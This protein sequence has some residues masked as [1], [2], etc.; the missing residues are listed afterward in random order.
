[1]AAQLGAEVTVVDEDGLGGACVLTDCVPS[2]TLI[3]SSST[4]TSLGRVG[5]ARPGARGRRQPGGRGGRAR[6]NARIKALAA[7]Q[8]N[9]IA[10]HV[11]RRGRADHRG[12][13]RLTGPHTIE[14]GGTTV[15]ADVRADRD[16]ARSPRVAARRGARRRAHPDLP[17]ALRPGRAAG[18]A[19]RGRL[20]RDRRRVRRAPTRRSARRSRWSRRAS[21]CCRTRTRTPPIVI[22]GVFRR[23]GMN[24]L[25][26]S[27]A[28]AVHRK[29]DG[30]VVTL[31]DGRH[32]DRLA[33][34][35]DGRHGAVH[36]RD[37]PAR[38]GRQPGQRA[39]SSRWT[40]CR[41]RRRPACTRPATA[42]AC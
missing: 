36:G 8:S 4:M 18:R 38:R 34:P 24:V 31:A 1:M 2:K 35:A 30:V 26:R 11:G 37:R 16:R 41:G 6:L 40:G 33:L 23:R 9:D 13:G 28:E 21:G 25:G 22:E 12:Q 27:R 19:D 39:A 20:R 15:H 3:E 29:G 42:R 10:E 14:A 7:A 17:P 32:G 5:L